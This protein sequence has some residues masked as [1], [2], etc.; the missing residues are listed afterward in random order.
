MAKSIKIILAISVMFFC[1]KYWFEMNKPE[2]L[3]WQRNIYEIE[4]PVKMP[5]IR[6]KKELAAVVAAMLSLVY[7]IR[8]IVSPPST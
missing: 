7:I 6:D 4:I 8:I 3:R 1:L 5:K 2:E